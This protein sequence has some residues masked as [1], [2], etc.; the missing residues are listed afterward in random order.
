MST[1]RTD[2]TEEATRDTLKGAKLDKYRLSHWLCDILRNFFSSPI[3]IHDERLV[4]LLFKQDGHTP[5]TCCAHFQ[6]ALPMSKDT[7]KAG[8]TPAVLVSAGE[9]TYPVQT[10]NNGLESINGQIEAKAMY[11]RYAFRKINMKVAV[12]TESLDGTELLSGIIEDFLVI[13]TL[14]L[15]ADNGA[16]SQFNVL[17][18]SEAQQIAIAEA[19]NAKELY[20]EVINLSVAG[21]VVWTADTQGPVYRGLT[22]QLHAE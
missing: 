18:S 21:S 15:Q 6:V 1:I 13:N 4:R 9:C 14:H 7:R 22:Q 20:Q 2:Y 17:G 8:I 5:D 19:M 12:L 3:N 16:V 10:F 11:Q